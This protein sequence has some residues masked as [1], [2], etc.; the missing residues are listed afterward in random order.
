VG[1]HPQSLIRSERLPEPI[2]LDQVLSGVRAAESVLRGLQRLADAP[3]VVVGIEQDQANTGLGGSIQHDRIKGEPITI[4]PMVEVVEFP[5]RRDAGIEH[6]LERSLRMLE[7]SVGV[8]PVDE[9]EHL[10]PPTPKPSIIAPKPLGPSSQRTLE[11]VRV[12][13]DEAWQERDSPEAMRGRVAE[14]ADVRNPS[15]GRDGDLH[16]GAERPIAPRE[17][18]LDD[19]CCHELVNS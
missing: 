4:D 6:L 9:G 11:R 16:T 13:I 8:Q 19:L 17:I 2:H 18:R 5:D 3:L 7:E 12:G 15:V 1:D 14:G 10:V